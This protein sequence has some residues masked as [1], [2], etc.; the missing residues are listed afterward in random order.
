MIAF[1]CLALLGIGMAPWTLA[2]D[3]ASQRIG[4]HVKALTGLDLAVEGRTTLAF[5][6]APRIKMEEVALRSEDGR[7]RLRTSQFRGEV[8]LLPLLRGELELSDVTLFEP[9]LNVMSEAQPVEA[10]QQWLDRLTR[11]AGASVV[12]RYPHVPRLVVVGGTVSFERS[13]G[14]SDRL[15]DVNVVFAWPDSASAIGAAGQF[16]YAG[17]AV[18][19]LFAGL[20]PTRLSTGRDSEFTLRVKAEGLSLVGRGTLSQGGTRFDGQVTCGTDSLADVDRWIGAGLPFAQLVDAFSVSGAT[21]LSP[22]GLAISAATVVVGN[23]QM[24]GAVSARVDGG[25]IALSGTLAADAL[26]LSR[27]ARPL[28][29]RLDSD[30]AWT[31]DQIERSAMLGSEL[32]LR[33]SASRATLGRFAMEDLASSIMLRS[34]RFEI[35]LSRASAYRGN[36]K[37]RLILQPAES[38]IDARLQGVMERVDL[39]GALS[40]AFD[41]RRVG[42][43]GSM[44]IVAEASGS[45]VMDLARS[46]SGRANVVVRQGEIV[47]IDFSELLRR[48][49]RRPL[50]AAS[51]WRGGRT[52][53]E[54][55]GLSLAIAGGVIELND[56][57]VS[58][59]SMKATL[60]G[61]MS[62]ADR[63]LALSGTVAPQPGSLRPASAELP[64]ELFGSWD[65]PRVGPD[66]KALIRRSGAAAPLLAPASQQK[67]P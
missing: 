24:E 44:Q 37:G 18:D 13:N 41:M 54:Q 61:Q 47:G 14:A 63:T 5:L 8:R 66:V 26:D 23:D 12:G 20:N 53:F 2:N 49:E 62:V 59:A 64:F 3:Y 27:F 42:G 56:A 28:T 34:G 51:D 6:P 58:T 29:P 60:A 38:G 32:D 36:V 67:T 46:L 16:S 25:R 9:T 57:T 1:A 33:I 30:R 55:A 22:R 21:T 35:T 31:R 45:S 39:A 65:D 19:V 11:T 7:V 48:A 15:K 50:S 17:R 43:I 10:W 52:S 4:K 40:D